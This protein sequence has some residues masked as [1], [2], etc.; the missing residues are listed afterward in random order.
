MPEPAPSGI[1]AARVAFAAARAAAKQRPAGAAKRKTATARTGRRSSGRDPISAMAAIRQMLADHGYE[2]PA[3]GGSV[4]DQWPAIAPELAGKVAAVGFDPESG[5]LSLRPATAA[6]GAQMRLSQRQMVARIA[7]TTGTSAVRSLRILP[8]QASP[9]AAPADAAPSGAGAVAAPG[10]PGGAAVK[11]RTDATPGLA[12]AHH[13][14]ATL[15]AGSPPP[16]EHTATAGPA[17]TLREPVTAF[18][19]TAAAAAEDS[20]PTTTPEEVRALA[21]ARARAEK[22]GPRAAAPGGLPRAV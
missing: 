8:P 9:L 1:D 16:A 13:L 22:A 6:Y 19:D 15:R 5:C 11:T 14:L 12:A 18:A 21:I 2:V 7:E 10:T 20:A 17:P 4:I 3:A